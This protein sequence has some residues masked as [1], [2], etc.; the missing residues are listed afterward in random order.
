MDIERE[1]QHLGQAEACMTSATAAALRGDLGGELSED[2]S[3]TALVRYA[4]DHL[5]ELVEQGEDLRDHSLS[6][7][8]ARHGRQVLLA[9][10]QG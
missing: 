5:G 6:S 8:V 7:E 10:L 9:Y 3:V 4:E 1:G 2:E